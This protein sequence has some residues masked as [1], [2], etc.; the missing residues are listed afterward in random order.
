MKFT[1]SDIIPAKRFL[2][3]KPLEK[4]KETENGLIMPEEGF[5]PTP[6]IGEVVSAGPESQYQVGQTVFFRRYS[7]DELK[8]Y[9]AGGK[10]AVVN[11]I[12]DDEVV[13]HIKHGNQ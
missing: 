5:S 13:A 8:F 11:L 2:I 1:L 3:V 7:V 9:D 12:S 6:V 10:I 4:P